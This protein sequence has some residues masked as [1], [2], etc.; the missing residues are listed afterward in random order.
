[1]TT[2]TFDGKT[3]AADTLVTS[4]SLAF[5]HMTKI[6]KLK[7]GG[8]VAMCGALAVAPEVIAWLEGGDKPTLSEEEEFGG[9]FVD[10]RGNAFE[11]S[12]NLR[13]HPACVPWAGGSGEHIAMAAMLC[14]KDAFEAVEVACKLDTKSREPID[15]VRIV[16]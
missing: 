1:M 7:G 6:H 15:S 10:K 5:G 3:L 11:I 9:L 16:K 13:L 14:G 8:H 12:G 2:I 4:G